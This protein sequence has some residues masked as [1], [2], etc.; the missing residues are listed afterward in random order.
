MNGPTYH[1]KIHAAPIVDIDIPP[2]PISADILRLLD[3]DYM[4][5]DNVDCYDS[6]GNDP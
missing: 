1:S 6:D 4:G 3:T 5:H 2:P